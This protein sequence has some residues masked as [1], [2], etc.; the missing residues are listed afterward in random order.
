MKEKQ[1]VSKLEK[2]KER[3]KSWI[4]KKRKKEKL[5]KTKERKK[6]WMRRKK[7][8]KVRKEERKKEKLDKKKEKE[9]KVGFAISQGVVGGKPQGTHL[10]QR[11]TSKNEILP[12]KILPLTSRNKT[13]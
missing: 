4:R 13:G 5:E 2:K 9:R 1:K 6:S 11:L 7:E 12:K 8:R 10:Q 3:K